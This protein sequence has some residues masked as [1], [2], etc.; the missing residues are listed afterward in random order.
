VLTFPVP[1][2]LHGDALADE[3]HAAGLTDASVYVD[4]DRLIVSDVDDADRTKV[5]SVLAAHV[6]P[7]PTPPADLAER[8]AAVEARL[9]KAA[10]V[11]VTG[12]AAKLRDNL[13]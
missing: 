8:L 11:A 7:V 9:D 5:E 13:R 12:D 10:S 2:A 4:R 1:A 3:L 6:P